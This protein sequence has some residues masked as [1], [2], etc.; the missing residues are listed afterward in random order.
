MLFYETLDIVK[1]K[2]KED[3]ISINDIGYNCCF[4]DVAI[5]KWLSKKNTLNTAGTLPYYQ[6]KELKSAGYI[7]RCE[8]VSPR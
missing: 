5:G 2:C 8:E 4:E 6:K 7:F 3:R 1:R